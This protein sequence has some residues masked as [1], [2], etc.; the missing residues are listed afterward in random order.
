MRRG[1]STSQGQL[2]RD[3][4]LAAARRIVAERGLAELSVQNV[5]SE[6]QVSK[7]A[8]SYHFGSKDGLILAL[9]EELAEKESEAAKKAVGRL[10][11]PAERFSAYLAL[12]LHLVQTSDHWR[13][14]FALWPTSHLDEKTRVFARSAASDLEA[15]HLPPDDPSALVLLSVLRAAITGLAFI[16]EARAPVMHLE[17]C[18]AHLE[19]ALTPSYLHAVA[20]AERPK[21]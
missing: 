5:V 4:I 6:A 12:Y 18:F 10:D 8:I 9:V 16:Y 21:G 7:S 3:R 19:R 14:A 11:D 15:L 20:A 1:D 17:A 2:P 13:L